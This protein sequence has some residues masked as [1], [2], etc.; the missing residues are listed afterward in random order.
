M[1]GPPVRIH[2]LHFGFF[3]VLAQKKKNIILAFCIDLFFPGRAY[4]ASL[5]LIRLSSL[6]SC[7]C[8]WCLPAEMLMDE[9]QSCMKLKVTD[10]A[11]EQSN[12]RMTNKSSTAWRRVGLWTKEK[13]ERKCWR[14]GDR[15]RV[16]ARHWPVCDIL[17]NLLPHSTVGDC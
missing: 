1:A 11:S 15:M 9:K 2:F 7:L 8:C 3:I 10:R 13:C 14:V 17:P 5:P 12:S 16:S 6:Q 4:A